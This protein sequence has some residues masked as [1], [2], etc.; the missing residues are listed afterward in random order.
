MQVERASQEASGKRVS[1]TLAT[2]PRDGNNFA[3]AKLIPDTLV[4]RLQN[5]QRLARAAWGGACGISAMWEGDCLPRI[6][7]VGDLRGWPPT[8]ELKHGPYAYGRQ[9]WGI[10]DN[11]RMPE[12]AM[13]SA[14]GRP[15]GCKLLL[16]VKKSSGLIP[17][18]DDG[19]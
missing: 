17:R 15:S 10:W 14:G 1:N 5:Q 6:V 12:R 4:S 2:C 3:K 16:S 8:M 9:Q 13:P 7:R 19:T 18:G 11:R